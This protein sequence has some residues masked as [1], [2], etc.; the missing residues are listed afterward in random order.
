MA[1]SQFLF[2][3]FQDTIAEY[4]Q[5]FSKDKFFLNDLSFLFE[6]S[7]K[8]AISPYAIIVALLYLKRLK[9]KTSNTNFGNKCSYWPCYS[10]KNL[11]E[12]YFNPQKNEFE[13]FGNTEFCLVS[14]VNSFIILF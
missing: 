2:N 13:N 8:R 6:M 12:S 4:V 9:T 11:I 3:S 1:N 14:I 7:R 5:G 10:A